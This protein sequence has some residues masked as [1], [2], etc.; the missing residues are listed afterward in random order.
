MKTMRS[1]ALR[2]LDLRWGRLVGPLVE[3]TVGW[4]VHVVVV[5]TELLVFTVKFLLPLA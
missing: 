3:F 5:V 4:F 1:F 2:L